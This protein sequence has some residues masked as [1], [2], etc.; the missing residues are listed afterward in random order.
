MKETGNNGNRTCRYV[1]DQPLLPSV[2]KTFR[3]CGFVDDKK[4][5]KYGFMNGYII[6]AVLSYIEEKEQDLVLGMRYNEWVPIDE[7]ARKEIKERII[8]YVKR[9]LVACRKGTSQSVTNSLAED[10]MREIDDYSVVEKS[11]CY[12]YVFGIYGDCIS[13]YLLIK[14]DVPDYD[15]ES[16]VNSGNHHPALEAFNSCVT[17]LKKW[18]KFEVRSRFIEIARDLYLL[19]QRFPDRPTFD[20]YML[21]DRVFAYAYPREVPIGIYS[22]NEA[23]NEWMPTIK[24]F[25]YTY[26]NYLTNS[27]TD[28]EK[29]WDIFWDVFS[30]FMREA[31]DNSR[32]YRFQ[33]R[34]VKEA[35]EKLRNL[36]SPSNRSGYTTTDYLVVAAPTG[37][38]KT[39]IMVLTILIVALARKVIL[40]VNGI[41]TKK[42]SPVAMMVYPRRALANDQVS[43]LIGYL[44]IL[45]NILGKKLNIISPDQ[46][47]TLTIDYTDIRKRKEYEDALNKLNNKSK[48]RQKLKIRYGVP[49]YFDP[50]ANYIEL[51]FLTCPKRLMG[52]SGT[53]YPRFKVKE[54]ANGSGRKVYEVDDSKVYC[55]DHELD[56]ISLTKDLVD[57]RP[58]DIHITIFETLRRRN[59]LNCKRRFDDLGLFGICRKFG[60][61]DVY[62][63]PLIITIDEIHTYVDIPG[64]RYAFT[65]RRLLNR[66]RYNHITRCQNARASPGSLII[67]LSATI[68]H[69]E[70]FLSNLF[71]SDNIRRNLDKYLLTVD[72]SETIPLGSEY[73]II[74]VPTRRAPVDA[75][76]VSL[77]TIMATFYNLPSIPSEEGY[78]KRSIVFMEEFNV[79]RRMRYE[80]YSKESGAIYRN[81]NGDFAYGLQ[82]L[83]NPRNELFIDR[84]IKDYEDNKNIIGEISRGSISK[85]VTTNSWHDG[86]LWWGYMLDT[87]LNYSEENADKNRVT[88][89]FNRVAE[90]SSRR[91]EDVSGVNVIVST[92]S[93][94][95]GVDYSDVV[96]TYQHGAPPNISALIQRAG[97]SGRRVFN[98]PLM[99]VAVGIQ[100]SPDEPRQSW[101][102]EIFT[103]VKNIRSALEYDMLFLPIESEELRKQTMAEVLLEYYALTK[104]DFTGDWECNLRKWIDEGD[105]RNKI[106]EYSLM[107][108]NKDNHIIREDLNKFLEILKKFLDKEC[109][110]QKSSFKR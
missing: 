96:L 102:F 25:F 106:V 107:I 68:P 6:N 99:R 37:S 97:R 51:G 11:I 7:Q 59:L 77:Q 8:E 26:H 13:R 94:E 58:G 45:N 12:L 86:E 30:E 24:G 89:R 61:S 63:Y 74:T 50:V 76:T 70:E 110:N 16:V 17:T 15:V 9:F 81:P 73:F 108:F 78:V 34:G 29:E 79:L 87:I 80:L 39:E 19:K 64:V 56:F 27:S 57:K 35:V 5:D 36:L 104:G 54:R 2:E 23:L 48:E 88:T 38:G 3:E 4:T 84:T 22:V 85:V 98:Y 105:N 91:R 18:D 92:S 55:G 90:Y 47:I 21:V 66:I 32:L 46:K 65:L 52:N 101:L 72:K 1:F 95:V 109:E 62:D 53:I 28:V 69:A 82:D 44:Y 83:R 43:R 20:S 10:L 103:R 67:G 33:V 93:L 41:D 31:F 75:L 14:G 49:A 60:N 100:L 71:L 40:L 42:N